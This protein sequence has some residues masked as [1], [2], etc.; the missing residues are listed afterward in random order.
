MD[1]GILIDSVR[2]DDSIVINN[3][4]LAGRERYTVG[5]VVV[6]AAVPVVRLGT[7]VVAV[8]TPVYDS[9]EGHC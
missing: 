7:G 2:S 5:P 1:T 8:V 9:L 6:D 4:D 3:A